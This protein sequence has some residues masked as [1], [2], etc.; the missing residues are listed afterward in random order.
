MIV[1]STKFGTDW[2]S[3][4]VRLMI[5]IGLFCSTVTNNNG[6]SF[7]QLT[8]FQ[9]PLATSVFPIIAILHNGNM[10]TFK[11]NSFLN[12]VYAWNQAYCEIFHWCVW[13]GITWFTW[14]LVWFLQQCS[15]FWNSFATMLSSVIAT[16]ISL[17]SLSATPMFILASAVSVTTFFWNK[18]YISLY[19]QSLYSIISFWI[20]LHN[21]RLLWILF[22]QNIFTCT[23]S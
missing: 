21:H 9:K 1:S 20:E 7:F 8:W 17:S 18:W 5:I 15:C 13:W 12:N 11:N 19:T 16:R 22:K 10:T 3:K 2:L 4:D 6:L 14:F 23:R